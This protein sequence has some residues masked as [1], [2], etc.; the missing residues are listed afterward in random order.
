[1]DISFT[2][3]KCGKKL[4]IDDA[5]AGIT[6]DCPECGKPVYVPSSASSPKPKEPPIRVEPKPVPR[7]PTPPP[8]CTPKP[9]PS[10]RPRNNPLVPSHPANQKTTVH[11]SISAGIHCLIILVAVEFVGFLMLRQNPLWT[12]VLLFASMPFMFAPLLCAAYGMGV[13][14]VKQ[15]LLVLAALALAI[16]LYYRLAVSMVVGPVEAAT[17][18]LFVLYG[19]MCIFGALFF[20]FWIW[21][22]VDCAQNEPPSNDKIVWMM[23]VI[24]LNW[25]GAI[26]YFFSRR[27]DRTKGQFS[28]PRPPSL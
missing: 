2:C 24:L 28:K 9:A 20:A 22:I 13:G 21:M 6:I 3:D 8:A 5:A 19:G 26:V 25:I 23:I 12:H 10:A 27:R 4:V 1:M 11:P 15:G 18:F 16:G 7:V 14:H 17:L